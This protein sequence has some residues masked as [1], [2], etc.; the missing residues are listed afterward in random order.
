MEL[1]VT[2]ERGMNLCRYAWLIT[3][4]FLRNYCSHFYRT[5]Y[6]QVKLQLCTF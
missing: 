5:S 6:K 1:T 3:V 4:I 2:G